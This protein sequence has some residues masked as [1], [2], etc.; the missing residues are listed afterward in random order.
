MRILLVE[1]DELI[2]TTLRADLE[3]AGFAV[4]WARDGV[5]GEYL[6]GKHPAMPWCW[7]LACRAVPG[8]RSCATGAPRI[9]G[10]QC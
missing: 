6:A 1:D 10:C 9:T 5:E 3:H 2:G 7:T 4:D 8:S